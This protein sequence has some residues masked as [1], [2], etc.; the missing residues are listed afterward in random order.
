MKTYICF[1]AAVIMTFTCGT[2]PSS[3]TPEEPAGIETDTLVITDSIGK[4]LGL[5]EHSLQLLRL[6][7]LLHDIG[8]IGV[9]RAVL[10]KPGKLSTKEYDKIKEHIKIG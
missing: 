10:N 2:E 1:A 6:G 9:A 4:K 5:D 3:V 8:K 7:S